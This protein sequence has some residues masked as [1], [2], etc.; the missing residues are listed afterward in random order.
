LFS[1]KKGL[2]K[3]NSPT[4]SGKKRRSRKN[5]ENENSISP[6]KGENLKIFVP[7]KDASPVKD[8]PLFGAGP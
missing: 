6:G 8:L 1:P 2:K 4:K 7:Q 5:D 3:Q